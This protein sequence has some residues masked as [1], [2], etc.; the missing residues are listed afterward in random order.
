MRLCR[1]N[2]AGRYGDWIVS[3]SKPARKQRVGGNCWVNRGSPCYRQPLLE[4]L[5]FPLSSATMLVAERDPDVIRPSRCYIIWQEIGNKTVEITATDWASALGCIYESCGDPV[6]AVVGEWCWTIN[7]MP[8]WVNYP[9]HSKQSK[10]SPKLSKT[11]QKPW[12]LWIVHHRTCIEYGS[13]ASEQFS[14]LCKQRNES[15]SRGEK[16]ML[17]LW[18]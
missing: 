8:H 12:T 11:I 17:H 16:K 2:A 6:V 15:A 7:D 5:S 4:T 10:T 18:P 3:I 9:R 1:C 13:R 14:A